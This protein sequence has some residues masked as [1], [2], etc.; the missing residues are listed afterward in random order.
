MPNLNFEQVEASLKAAKRRSR[1]RLFLFIG[2]I[3]LLWGSTYLYTKGEFHFFTKKIAVTDTIVIDQSAAIT[4]RDQIINDQS[5]L[6]GFLQDS[7]ERTIAL[8]P[9]YTTARPATVKNDSVARL[10]AQ[11]RLREIERRRR[12]SILLSRKQRLYEYNN[13]IQQAPPKNLQV[14]PKAQ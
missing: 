11:I 14:S 8:L 2:L 1:R 10:L 4:A 3:L 5:R 9:R 6:I 7:L 12:D 13:E